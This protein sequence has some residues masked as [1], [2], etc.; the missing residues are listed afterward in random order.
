MTDKLECYIHYSEY[1]L[2]HNHPTLII[3]G[4]L[5]NIGYNLDP[6]TGAVEERTCV[7]SAWCIDECAC[8]AWDEFDEE[9][10]V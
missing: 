7:C 3:S 6:T 8:G 1:D 2:N 5:G 10:G 4:Q 9:D